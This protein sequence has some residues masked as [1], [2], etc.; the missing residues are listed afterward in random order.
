[1][2][3]CRLAI[4]NSFDVHYNYLS[5][6]NGAK[7]P[8]NFKM[9]FDKYMKGLYGNIVACNSITDPGSPFQSHI[10]QSNFFYGGQ[11]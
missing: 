4:R 10:L 6:Y 3:K 7:I 9:E 8:D 1:M 11:V 5:S 2:N